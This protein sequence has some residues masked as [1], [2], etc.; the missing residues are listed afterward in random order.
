VTDGS[1][2]EAFGA[3]LL[4]PVLREA[5]AAVLIVDL[6]QRVVTFANDLAG[7]LAP[8]LA[9]PATLDEWSSAAGLE[10]VRGDALPA[11]GGAP[12]DAVDAAAPGLT[13]ESLLRVAQGQPVTGEAV[14][15]ARQ[16][17][18]TAAREVLWVVGLPLIDAPGS[19][20]AMSL[21]V[22][23]PARNARLI[24][25]TQESAVTLRERAVL[26]TRM[27]FTITDPRQPDNP[28]VWVNPAFAATTG[29][30]VDEAIGRNCRFLQGPDTEPE[31]VERIRQ[32]LRAEQPLTTTLLNYR[33]DGTSF[34][35]EV[36]I[37]PVHDVSGTVTHFVGVQADVTSRVEAQRA[38]DDA[39]AQVAVA[40]DRL[41]LLA[42]FTSRLS[43]CR[44]PEH[45]VELLSDVLVPGVGTWAVIYTVDE[46]GRPA[47]PHIRHARADTDPAVR[48]S[49]DALRAAVP[50]QL[51]AASPVWRVL[52]GEQPYVLIEDYD[53]APPEVTGAASDE[54]TSLIRKLGMRGLIAVPLLARGGILGCVALVADDAARPFGDTELALVRD[55]SVRAA[56]MLENAQLHARDRDVAETLQRSLLPRLVTPPG[57]TVA[58]SYV[59]AADEAAV[60][61]DWYDV[62]ALHGVDLGRLGVVVGDVMGHNIDSA[63]RMGKLSTILRAYGWPGSSP[64]EVLAA[65]DELL[66][67]SALD[68][69]ATCWYATLTPTDSGVTVRYS[70]AGH[71]PPVVRTPDGRVVSL[72]AGRGPMLGIS[73]LRRDGS[74]RPPDGTVE[75]VAGST[76]ICFTDGLVDAF[77]ADGDLEV[78]LERLS[79]FIAGLDPAAAPQ[80]LVDGLTGYGRR[81]D[82]LAVVAIRID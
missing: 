61:G 6:Q 80:Q 14:T 69:L 70:S 2:E 18:A 3:A 35:N 47:H 82:D 16:T 62:F 24:S 36:T 81:K 30:P 77:A 43:M 45:V 59:P 73:V 74:T 8:E 34:W 21:L 28:L 29:Y 51:Q 38:R 17:S 72:A 27:S 12:D 75:L 50:A 9:L 48:D 60:G 49:L 42:D 26:A 66:V 11:G 64:G 68:V 55:L 10:D 22:F 19:L 1:A 41:A 7:Q 54:R 32:H 37:S 23:L 65:V 40:A 15:A 52:R 58:A 31:A 71:P 33:K 44:Q 78:G 63:A 5:S 56:L 53:A 25:D 67:G 79:D 4:S 76:L 46:A 57:M 20:G 13:A 39:M